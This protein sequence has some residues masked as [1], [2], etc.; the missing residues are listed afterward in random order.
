M[1]N[2]ILQKHHTLGLTN[3]EWDIS[4]AMWNVHIVLICSLKNK[5]CKLL[6]FV[7]QSDAHT[8]Y[9]PNNKSIYHFVSLSGEKQPM[10]KTADV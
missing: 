2:S 6:F 1:K 5:N 10:V 4:V 9:P 3:H 8:M 7:D